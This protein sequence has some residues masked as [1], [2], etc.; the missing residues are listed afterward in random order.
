MSNGAR[1]GLMS[2]AELTAQLAATQ[3]AERGRLTEGGEEAMGKGTETIYRDASGRIINIGMKRAEARAKAEEE[4]KRKAEEE[5]DA[6][7]DVQ[8]VMKEKRREEVRGA[9]FMGVA[10]YADDKEL[11]AELKEEERWND[12][13]AGFLVQKKKGRS[14]TG[15]PLYA[16]AAPPNRYGIRPGHK[17]DGVD[18][19]GG[20]ESEWFKAR[21]RQKSLKD[22][23]YAWQMDE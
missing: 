22:L 15:R 13:A 4:A 6:R 23:D 20:F 2:A 8:R 21:N 16:G 19:G 9:K 1:A 11:N 17:W 14:V 5:E 10:R 3:A 7:G 18:R 12:P